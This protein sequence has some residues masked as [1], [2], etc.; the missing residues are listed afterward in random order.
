MNMLINLSFSEYMS[1]FSMGYVTVV[2]GSF[3]RFWM[4]TNKCHETQKTCS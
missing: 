4:P 3:S 1:H 2:T